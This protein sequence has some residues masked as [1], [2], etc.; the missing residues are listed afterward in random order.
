MGRHVVT[1]EEVVKTKHVRNVEI[2]LKH[3][4]FCGGEAE[5]RIGGNYDRISGR[6]LGTGVRCK[7]CHVVSP[8]RQGFD[9]QL[10]AAEL[11]NKRVSD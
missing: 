2:E 8:V 7:D 5:F 6:R 10:R 9:S 3:C 11:W 1:F 4:P